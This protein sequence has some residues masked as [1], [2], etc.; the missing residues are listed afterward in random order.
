MVNKVL[1]IMSNNMYPQFKS[2][3]QLLHDTN[4]FFHWDRLLKEDYQ[5]QYEKAMKYV[6]V[7]DYK[8]AGE[9][10]YN[11]AILAERKKKRDLSEFFSFSA[12]ESA[13]WYGNPEPLIGFTQEI[14][15][16]HHD[17]W[18][19]WIEKKFGICAVA[20]LVQAD[21]SKDRHEAL[22]LYKISG[23]FLS[24]YFEK[25]GD[26]KNYEKE[27]IYYVMYGYCIYQIKNSKAFIS[28]YFDMCRNVPERYC[29]MVRE[30]WKELGLGDWLRKELNI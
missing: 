3:E 9:E 24:L 1:N 4:D 20:Y 19:V 25:T 13:L 12:W 11:A 6:K 5:L 26:F 2:W 8:R 30:K 10:F 7:K 17:T 15:Q 18:P 21:S 23:W 29:D 22:T 28:F 14:Y 16:I 27:W